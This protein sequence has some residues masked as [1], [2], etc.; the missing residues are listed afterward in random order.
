MWNA[1]INSTVREIIRAHIQNGVGI[2]KEISVHIIYEVIARLVT[3]LKL[4]YN[5]FYIYLMFLF[6]LYIMS[7]LNFV[8]QISF[9]FVPEMSTGVTSYIKKLR[10]L[11][12]QR[13]IST[14]RPPLVCKVSASFSG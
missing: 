13:T 6:L 3:L 12:R 11:V 10:G 14:E 5:S 1:P 4:I 8:F 2:C 7:S 9:A